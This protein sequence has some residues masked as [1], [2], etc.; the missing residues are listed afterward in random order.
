MD[1]NVSPAHAKP[2]RSGRAF[3]AVQQLIQAR[4]PL[5]YICSVEEPRV[6]QLLKDA[7]GQLLP[8]GAALWTWSLTGGLHRAGGSGSIESLDPRGVLEF[9]AAQDGPAIFQLRDFHEFMGVPEI[10]RRLRDLYRLCFDRG[11][12][13][14]ITSPVR[15]IPEEMGH[16]VAL[17]E[18]Q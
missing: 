9:I 4:R 5:I 13:V 2:T 18:L 3:A 7:A 12:F 6:D 1:M 8:P 10:R 15:A 16:Q 14:V 17:L 11:K